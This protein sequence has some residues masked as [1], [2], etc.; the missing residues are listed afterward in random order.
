MAP[1]EEPGVGLELPEPVDPDPGPEVDVDV[2]LGLGLGLGPPV[3]ERVIKAGINPAWAAT[4]GATA[5]V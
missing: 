5:S 4:A 3:G 2:P 1:A